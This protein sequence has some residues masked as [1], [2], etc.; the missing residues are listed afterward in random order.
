VNDQEAIPPAVL[1]VAQALVAGGLDICGTPERSEAPR[2]KPYRVAEVAAELDVHRATVYRDVEA[3]RCGAYRI[4][5]GSG[6][7]RISVEDFEKYKAST[8]AKAVTRNDD[9]VAS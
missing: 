7:I 8:K 6:A 9:A 5:Q 3:G 2:Q 4:G 1:K